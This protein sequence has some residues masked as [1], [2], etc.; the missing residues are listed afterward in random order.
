MPPMLLLSVSVYALAQPAFALANGGAR[1]TIAPPLDA[2]T[3]SVIVAIGRRRGAIRCGST[4]QG[5]EVPE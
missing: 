5:A 4:V 2:V 1:A 3:P